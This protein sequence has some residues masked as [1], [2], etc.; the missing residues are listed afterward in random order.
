MAKD[1]FLVLC[2]QPDATLEQ[3]KSAYRGKVKRWHPDHCDEGN[4]PFLAIQEA[5]ECWA[6][7]GHRQS[8][9]IFYWPTP[10]LADFLSAQKGGTL[11]HTK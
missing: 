4:K 3:I 11:A 1:Y 8:L 9:S 6:P 7:D 2:I 10:I 5:Y